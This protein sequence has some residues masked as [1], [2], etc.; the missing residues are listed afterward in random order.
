M[1]SF[2]VSDLSLQVISLT[3]T[4]DRFSATRILHTQKKSFEH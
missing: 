3:L 1:T 4:V 2:F